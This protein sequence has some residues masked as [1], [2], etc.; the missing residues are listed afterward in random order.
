MNSDS[1]EELMNQLAISGYGSGMSEDCAYCAISNA[2]LPCTTCSSV[3]YC[4]ETCKRRHF[5][6]HRAYCIS[7]RMMK[8]NS[9]G[10]ESDAEEESESE[11]EEMMQSTRRLS[12]RSSSASMR[13][14]STLAN[15]SGLTEKQVKNLL[16]LAR[17]ADGFTNKKQIDSLQKQITQLME[18]QGS[19]VKQTSLDDSSSEIDKLYRK[20]SELEKKTHSFHENGGSGRYSMP[21]MNAFGPSRLIYTPLL[22]KDDPEFRKY[23]KLKDM[24][25]PIEQ[26]RLKMENDGVSEA[27]LDTPNAVSP[28]DP[29]PTEGAYI[30]MTVDEDPA[31]VKYFKLLRLDMPK[32]QIRIKME[33]DGVDP[34]LLDHPK[35]ASPNDPGPSE[36]GYR[37][38]V[39]EMNFGAGFSS[40]I[41]QNPRASWPLNPLLAHSPSKSHVPLLN[42]DDP[43]LEKYFK[44][45]RMGM[46]MEQIKLKMEAEGIDS[47]LI[48]KPD[49]ISPNDPGPASFSS[50]MNGP[51]TIEQLFSVVMQQQQLL[52]Q[53]SS[54][55]GLRMS[56]S[57]DASMPIPNVSLADQMASEMAS[58]ESA[59]DDIFG[60][61]AQQQGKGS[62]INMIEQ[63]EKKARRDINKK[64]VKHRATIV[65][66][67][68]NVLNAKF[69]SD[70]DA[71]AY[72]KDVLP[73][74]EALGL[75]L[76]TD[77]VQTWSARLLIKNKDTRDWYF[78]EKERLD[79]G[80]AY[81]RLWALA[82]LE[83]D[84]GQLIS[85]RDQILNAPQTLKSSVKNKVELIDR[86][87]QLLKDAVK[88]KHKIFKNAL[89]MSEIKRV[90]EYNIPHQMEA[91]AEEMVHASVTLATASMGLA[92]EEFRIL[93][94]TKQAQK[95][96]A[97]TAVFVAERVIQFVT[98]V[99]KIG[100]KDIDISRLDAIKQNLDDVNLKFF[101]E[102]Q[103]EEEEDDVL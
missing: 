69:A 24:N 35:R 42:K 98:I 37:M 68:D 70:V 34:S 31:F 7:A 50:V 64:L 74:L 43:S 3:Y 47:S 95:I 66:V 77:A 22:V 91:R 40:N 39:P 83:R 20:L 48:E 28:N 90:E 102:E 61:E 30:P 79:A 88:L 89:Y 2:S 33:A 85:K 62:G 27:L 84:A 38:S 63:L 11:D 6:A 21:Q 80:K 26:I 55:G 23:F 60:D 86:F 44:L 94:R 9:E 75:S 49:E 46:P 41:A 13:L 10:S 51:V 76:G 71:I 52:Q 18:N 25:M 15:S 58:A 96:R 93:Q 72:S 19:R 12:N 1:D 78:S 65:E 82:F 5:S 4:S 67:I 103:E 59:I 101:S 81:L 57:L 54:G 16:E 87:T 56:G 36:N 29:G 92:E 32:E 97:H 100:A 73:K 53:V 45:A 8:E 14:S 99:Q 17:K